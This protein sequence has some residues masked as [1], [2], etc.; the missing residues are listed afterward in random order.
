M[1]SRPMLPGSC[2]GSVESLYGA[3][4]ISGTQFCVQLALYG[5]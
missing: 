5:M 4:E 1:R 3:I 2:I